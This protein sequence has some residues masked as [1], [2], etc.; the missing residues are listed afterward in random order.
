[1]PGYSTT[2]LVKKLG[3][4]EGFRV[5]FVNSPKGFE[6]ELGRLPGDVQIA[7]STLILEDNSR[8]S[9]KIFVN[10]ASV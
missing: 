6:K 1:M 10:P 9:E 8:A 2:P 5:G 4:K 7:C 3:I